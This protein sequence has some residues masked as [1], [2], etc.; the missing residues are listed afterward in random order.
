MTHINP[1]IDDQLAADYVLGT[2][3][4]R[5]RQR[6]E[7]ILK[8]NPQ[9]RRVVAA[10]EARLTPMAAT[11]PEVAPPQHVWQ[12]IQNRI[13]GKRTMDREKQP[14]WWSSLGFWRAATGFATITLVVSGLLVLSPTENDVATI[15]VIDPA[16]DSMMV[17]VMEDTQT[18]APAMTVSWESGDA[19]HNNKVLRLRV[20]GHAEMAPDTAWEL[21]M[22]P[23]GDGAP[24]SLGLITTHELQMLRVPRVLAQPLDDAWGL[25]MTVEPRG[26]SPSGK[27]TGPMLY[28]GKCIMA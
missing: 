17:V 15:P 22:M 20:I 3:P 27:P 8:T 19:N 18:Q 12:A 14:N 21:W 13:F 4:A 1:K 5:T 23:R 6:F 2:M 7:A 9:L 25:G 26:G 11:V 24:I 16:A 10:W 28:R